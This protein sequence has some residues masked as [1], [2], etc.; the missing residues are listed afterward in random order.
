MFDVFSN[1]GAY[2][3]EVQ[4]VSDSLRGN[5]EITAR[6]VCYIECV[7]F[8]GL[9]STACVLVDGGRRENKQRRCFARMGCDIS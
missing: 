9:F 4:W 2:L 7:A 8:R 6:L 3:V 1:K 5:S